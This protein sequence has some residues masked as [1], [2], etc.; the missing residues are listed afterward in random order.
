MLGSSAL[1]MFWPQLN[2]GNGDCRRKK[3]VAVRQKKK[4][5]QSSLRP[6][7]WLT[8]T[9]KE[10]VGISQQNQVKTPKTFKYMQSLLRCL[11]KYF[12]PAEIVLCRLV[13]CMRDDLVAYKPKM[14]AKRSH[15]ASYETWEEW[16]TLIIP[17]WTM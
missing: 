4:T 7:D 9:G 5:L 11:K 16:N 13:S 1:E 12:L 14:A 17:H 10:V 2:L 15:T 8:G 3:Q 6:V